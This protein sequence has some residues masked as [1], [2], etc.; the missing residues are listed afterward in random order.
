MFLKKD[1]G[2]SIIKLLVAKGLIINITDIFR[3]RLG[4]LEVLEGF[5]EKKSIKILKSIE[6]SKEISLNNFIY[7]L[8]IRHIGQESSVLLA[9]YYQDINKLMNSKK[10]ELESIYSLGKQSSESLFSYFNNKDNRKEIKDLFSLG[11]KIKKEKKSNILNNK[12]FLFSGS[13]NI[14]RNQIEEMIR[15]N[16]GKIL[17][18]VSPN[19]DYLV[20]GSKPGSKLKKAQD[21]K[22]KIINEKDILSLLKYEK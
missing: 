20:I 9:D 11:I 15:K 2:K 13:L 6:R 3:L 8:G 12:T 17:S 22:I 7:A 10:E 1:L 18:N 5:A 19:L 21:L 14:A 16:G 4:D